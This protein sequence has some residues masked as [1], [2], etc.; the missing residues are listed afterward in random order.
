MDA[1]IAANRTVRIQIAETGGRLVGHLDQTCAGRSKV[2][3]AEPPVANIR[4]ITH[5]YRFGQ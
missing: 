5:A 1:V 3:S 2:S 4:W